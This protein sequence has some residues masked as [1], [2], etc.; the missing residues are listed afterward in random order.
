MSKH[1]ERIVSQVKYFFVLE[2]ISSK[3]FKLDELGQKV[4]EHMKCL[5]YSC[6]CRG[7][8]CSPEFSKVFDTWNVKQ[9]I[10]AK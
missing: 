9:Y 1:V 2:F 4:K 3:P 8:I 5:H 10:G 6:G 7:I